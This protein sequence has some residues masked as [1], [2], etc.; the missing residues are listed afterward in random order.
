MAQALRTRLY[1]Q[2]PVPDSLLVSKGD[3]GCP[4]M[5]PALGR[6]KASGPWTQWLPVVDTTPKSGNESHPF[7]VTSKHVC[8]CSVAQCH[9]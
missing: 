4:V 8:I 1:D 5:H 2:L 9:L 7:L 3:A 6:E